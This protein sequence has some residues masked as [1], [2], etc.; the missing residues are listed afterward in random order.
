MTESSIIRFFSE[1]A[2]YKQFCVCGD[3]E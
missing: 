3:Y 1:S 2:I